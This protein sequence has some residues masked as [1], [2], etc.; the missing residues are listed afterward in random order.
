MNRNIEY[1]PAEVKVWEER[2]KEVA[3][4]FCKQASESFS[5]GLAG[6]DF[7]VVG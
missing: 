5:C 4:T 1:V 7:T 6:V 3:S 2:E